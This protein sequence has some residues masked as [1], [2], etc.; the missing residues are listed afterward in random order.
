MVLQ[1]EI[2]DYIA[3]EE[4][5]GVDDTLSSMLAFIESSLPPKVRKEDLRFGIP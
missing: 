4:A 3:I 1:W 2:L 5:A